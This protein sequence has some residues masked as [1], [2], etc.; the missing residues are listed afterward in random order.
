[1]FLSI[2]QGS[3]LV[4]HQNASPAVCEGLVTS[5]L[6]NLLMVFA[7]G[8]AV[9]RALAAVLNWSRR[10]RGRLQ[11]MQVTIWAHPGCTI[12]GRTNL[13]EPLLSLR[14]LRWTC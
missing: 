14:V 13:A 1:M 6:L 11:L 12:F 9:F 7:A 2:T 4:I 5:V 3:M 10:A 8:L